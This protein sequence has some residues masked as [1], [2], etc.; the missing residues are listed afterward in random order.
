[1]S[2]EH[3]GHFKVKMGSERNFGVVFGAVFA[4]IGLWP[5]RH[6]EAFLIWPLVVA[7]IFFGLGL[8]AP[9]LLA[10]LNKIWFKFGMLLGAVIAPI[11]MA[12]VYFVAVTPTGLFKRATGAD[13]L[14]QKLDAD[15]DSYWLNRNEP[16]GP[17]KNQF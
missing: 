14:R 11:V 9:K 4:I 1:M 12:L 6:G 15:A 10:P 16:I 2:A 17:M 5:L 8:F 13:L 7:G 3:G